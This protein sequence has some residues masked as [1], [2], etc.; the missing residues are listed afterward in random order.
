MSKKQINIKRKGQDNSSKALVLYKNKPKRRGNTSTGNYGAQ[1]INAMKMGVGKSLRMIPSTAA[2]GKVYMDPWS[3][4]EARLPI[5]P[6]YSTKCVRSTVNGSGV[7]N[8]GGI[9]F[10]T[11]IPMNG[12]CNDKNSVFWSNAAASPPTFETDITTYSI[13]S[14]ASAKTG[15]KQANFLQAEEGLQVRCVGYGIRIRYKGTTLNAAGEWYACQTNPKFSLNAYG[16]DDVQKVQGYKTHTFA[17]RKW[18]GYTRMLTSRLDAEYC[19]LVPGNNAQNLVNYWAIP[20]TESTSPENMNYMGILF[21]GTPG[22][23]F[24]FE[25]CGHY[26]IIGPNLDTEAIAPV[27]ETNAH[28]IVNEGHRL[29]HTD[30]S[31]KD[32]LM[33]DKGSGLVGFLKKAAKVALPLLGD[34]IGLGSIGKKIANLI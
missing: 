17:D 6:V 18:N 25:V 21:T 11:T 9:G 15:F 14:A 2:F 4:Q 34:T 27:D 3:K 24:E 30:T 28:N 10:V 1:M 26:E 33:D 22:E 12:I 19:Q 7:L 16:V 8:S 32:H 13:G 29:R 23:P 5:L 20:A 31:T